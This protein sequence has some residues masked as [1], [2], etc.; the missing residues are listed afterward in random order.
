MN[1]EAFIRGYL[2]KISEGDEE[3]ISQALEGDLGVNA[4]LEATE[5]T[6]A[7][8]PDNPKAN[9]VYTDDPTKQEAVIAEAR[10]KDKIIIP[11]GLAENEG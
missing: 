8:A 4:Q 6:V 9:S 11:D 3:V 1:N 10:L 7:D 2:F 5:K